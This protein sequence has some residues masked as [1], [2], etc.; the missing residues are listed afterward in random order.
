[1]WGFIKKRKV[2]DKIVGWICTPKKP[3]DDTEHKWASIKDQPKENESGEI[4]VKGEKLGERY[5]KPISPD[6]LAALEVRV[7][8]LEGEVI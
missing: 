4:F 3:E 2:D 7:A 6:R 5:I 8:T 1:M